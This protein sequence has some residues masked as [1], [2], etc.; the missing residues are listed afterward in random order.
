[1]AGKANLSHVDSYML[2]GRAAGRC[3]F[4]GCNKVLHRDSFDLQSL[5][6]AER[7]HIVARSPKGPRGNDVKSEILVDNIDNVML[8]CRECHARI[9]AHPDN[10]P[11]QTLM[12]MKKRHED[13]IEFLTGFDDNKKS[14]M[15]T[16][17]ANIGERR[18]PIDCVA[19][20]MSMI[21]NGKAPA[22]TLAIDLSNAGNALR[23]NEPKFW[24][25]EENNLIAKFNQKL[26]DR[27]TETGDIKHVS[28]FAIA[29]IPLLIKLGTLF[30]DKCAM[31]VFQ[32]R[33]EPD[34]WDWQECDSKIKINLISPIKK[35]DNVALV[36]SLSGEILED[37]VCEAIGADASI[38]HLK[39]EVPGYDCI[40][41]QQDLSVF[42]QSV[43]SVLNQIKKRHGTNC[44]IHTFV[45]APLSASI[46]IGRVWMPR[47]DLP[48]QT[49]NRLPNR[50]FKK[51]LVI[52]KVG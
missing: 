30:T 42:R 15:V 23:D 19:A 28:L 7:A 40:S 2:W 18:A 41:T 45:A 17:S 20:V 29:P 43:R 36:I 1:M 14:H 5:N 16:Y 37:D 51:A 39:A 44:I 33:R 49:Y 34:T 47:A 32:K 12:E 52:G 26:L 9:D 38:W 24:E 13:R 10:F 4:D 48:L 50:K 11:I 46:E 22:E 31:D 21:R 27:I 6:L 3:E 25:I 8:L 35:C